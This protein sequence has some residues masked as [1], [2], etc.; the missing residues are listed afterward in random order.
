MLTSRGLIA[1][2]VGMTSLVFW[3]LTFLQCP[4]PSHSFRGK[5]Y[6]LATTVVLTV[7]CI[8]VC[9]ADFDSWDSLLLWCW[10]TV[11]VI[12]L[13]TSF[14]SPFLCPVHFLAFLSCL[15]YARTTNQ[16]QSS[17]NLPSKYHKVH[18]KSCY[19][20]SRSENTTD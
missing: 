3:T 1:F 17:S 16:I 14:M 9:D 8:A 18:G 19:K 6:T 20:F 10:P 13:V 5:H 11:S 12:T 4:F 2:S 15:T 7:L